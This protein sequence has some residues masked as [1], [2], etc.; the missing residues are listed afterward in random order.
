VLDDGTLV[1]RDP[2]AILALGEGGRFTRL[3][4]R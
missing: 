3:E 4:C 2:G 1:V